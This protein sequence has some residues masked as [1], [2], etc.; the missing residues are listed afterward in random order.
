MLTGCQPHPLATSCS[1]HNMTLGK[2]LPTKYMTHSSTSRLYSRK[3]QDVPFNVQAC[4]E[5]TAQ[6]QMLYTKSFKIFGWWV[7]LLQYE[8]VMKCIV[9][10]EI[11]EVNRFNQTT[12]KRPHIFSRI[13]VRISEN[14]SQ[15][16]IKAST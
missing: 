12:S 1:A 11:L 14:F 6:V 10:I 13:T 9:H 3:D 5:K 8:P 4:T 15:M 16:C 2:R 7:E